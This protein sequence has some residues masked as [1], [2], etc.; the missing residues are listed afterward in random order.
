LSAIETRISIS[1]STNP[2]SASYRDFAIATVAVT[3]FSSTSAIK[4]GISC[5]QCGQNQ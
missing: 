3:R 4:F 2:T 5:Q 1:F